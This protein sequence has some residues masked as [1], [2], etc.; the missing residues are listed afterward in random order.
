MLFQHAC[1]GPST[2]GAV[3]AGVKAEERP[4]TRTTI[5]SPSAMFVVR[6]LR[7]I[8]CVALAHFT[9]LMRKTV[10]KLVVNMKNNT[11]IKFK[12]FFFL[13]ERFYR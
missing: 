11:N 5:D 7:K 3:E 4:P 8:R 10:G 2:R 13:N 9:A 1:R 6:C 12:M